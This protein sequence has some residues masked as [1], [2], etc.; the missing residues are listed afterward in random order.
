MSAGKSTTAAETA[1]ED[2]RE[3]ALVFAGVGLF[4]YSLDGI[5]MAMDRNA[6]RI[7][8]IDDRF[9]DP[10]QVVGKK[11]AELFTGGLP[12]WMH[13]EAILRRRQAHNLEYH[14]VTLKGTPKWA[15]HNSYP[16]T[17]SATRSHYI[18]AIIHDITDV[19]HA[20][21]EEI[22]QTKSRFLSVLT[23]ELRTPLANIM[24]WAREALEVP[25]LASEALPIILRNAESESRML[26]NLLEVSRLFHG[27]FTLQCEK[28]DLWEVA[29][30]AL[31]TMANLAEA[32]KI[33]LVPVPP[34][35]KL[36]VH[37]DVRRLYEVICNLL[38]NAAK[39][40]PSGGKVTLAA[41]PQE[42]F[43]RLDVSDTGQGI[44]PDQLRQL[45]RPFPE[46]NIRDVTSG[47]HLGL[48]LV[49]S[50]VELHG[51]NVAVESPGE[52]LGSTF[53]VI[54]PSG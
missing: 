23:H 2:I 45:F 6:M 19:V 9:A 18:Q 46:P 1:P 5:V 3:T 29:E 22:E 28:T 12:D 51:G 8:E 53:S 54:L 13:P 48:A 39:F 49:K 50:V 30:R 20:R 16:V 34:G 27:H 38:D 25:G 44:A 17:D 26:N 35:R 42:R 36:P 14:F 11:L 33:E 4:S 47:L 7:L 40:T 37:A 52:G 21:R 32:H 41:Y 15:L 10:G 24:G 31:R 43:V